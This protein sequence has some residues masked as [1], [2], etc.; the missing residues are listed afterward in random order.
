MNRLLWASIHDV[1]EI[2]CRD[3]DS[4][5]TTI[6]MLLQVKTPHGEERSKCQVDL[7]SSEFEYS[8]SHVLQV[9]QHT[10]KAYQ[11]DHGYHLRDARDA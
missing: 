8:Y 11:Q 7:L 5:A 10:S 4:K 2:S 9:N 3:S 6:F 1:G